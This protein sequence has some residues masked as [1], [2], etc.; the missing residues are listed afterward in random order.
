[1]YND[2]LKL[3]NKFNFMSK[4]AQKQISTELGVYQDFL[5]DNRLVPVDSRGNP[6]QSDPAFVG[7]FNEYANM[8]QNSTNFVFTL[9]IKQNGVCEMS[10]K[11][12]GK[13]M[14]KSR[15]LSKMESRCSQAIRKAILQGKLAK[16]DAPKVWQ[17]LSM[18]ITF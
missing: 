13:P 3:A 16:P 15:T 9:V 12:N 2:I 5:I 1:M 10:A 7:L 18:K 17:F 8:V 14:R 4:K 11:G 6:K